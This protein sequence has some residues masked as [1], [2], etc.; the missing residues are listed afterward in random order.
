V[1]LPSS[2]S[3]FRRA[4]N[5]WFQSQNIRPQIIAELDDAALAS[6]F[7][8]AGLGVFAVPDVIE[9]EVRSR[10]RVE[11][12]GRVKAIRQRFYAISVERKIRHPAVAAIC[13]AARKHIFADRA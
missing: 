8:E 10:Y 11:L 13:A 5:E 4:L 6:V 12:V 2:D 7:A 9:G 1:L 3:T